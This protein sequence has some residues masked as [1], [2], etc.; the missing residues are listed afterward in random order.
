VQFYSLQ[1]GQAAKQLDD[2]A[3][4]GR[5]IDLGSSLEDFADTAAVLSQLDLLVCVDTSVAHLAGA[6][7]CPVW[8]LLPEPADS[9][10]LE[11]REDTPWYPTMR[12]FRQSRRNDWSEPIERI[13]DTLDQWVRGRSDLAQRTA[14]HE[15]PTDLP[16]RAALLAPPRQDPMFDAVETRWG[17]VQITP[18]STPA[19]KSVYWYGEYLPH[20]LDLLFGL[21]ATGHTMVEVG[22]GFGVHGLPLSRAVG[23]SG[24]LYVTEF[25]P[26]ARSILEANVAANRIGNCTLLRGMARGDAS[27]GNRL[28]IDDFDFDRLDWIKS[29]DPDDGLDVLDGARDSIARCRPRLLLV[30]DETR[31]HEVSRRMSEFGYRRWHVS[32]PLFPRSN[33]YRRVTNVFGDGTVL[34]ILG[35]PRE[36]PCR[37]DRERCVEL[38]D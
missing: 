30:V 1:K 28:V 8:M 17:I 32:S 12:L 19:A 2:G 16:S 18:D 5:I 34:S 23:A 14:L 4:A 33:F 20:Q 21:V 35:V 9:R 24:H 6:V 3:W 22:S 25:D 38:T 10:W 36:M 15:Q 7:G 27:E 26:V 37:I 29:N 31:A 11:H 13:R